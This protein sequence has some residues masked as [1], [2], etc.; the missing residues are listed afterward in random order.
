MVLINMKRLISKEELEM[1]MRKSLSLADVLK[2]LKLCD[3]GKSRS[4]IRTLA[5]E[6]NIDL[7]KL[8]SHAFQIKYPTVTKICPQCSNEFKTQQGHPKETTCCSYKC[9][10]KFK[11]KPCSKEQKKNIRMGILKYLKISDLRARTQ[12]ETIICPHCKSSFEAPES[13]HRIYCSNRCVVSCKDLREKNKKAAIE[14]V[15][16]GTHKGWK[17]RKGRALSYPEQFF[18]TV[19]NNNKIQFEHDLP[20]G[21]WFVDFAMKDKM[22]ALEIDGKQHEY[23][24]RKIKDIEKDTYLQSQGWTVHRIKWKSINNEK[25]SLYIKDE[26]NKFLELYTSLA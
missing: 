10:N 2:I 25:G 7:S 4:L 1:A 5:G 24:E 16:N 11:A 12:I 18:E 17:S 26:I 22:I 14:R 3:N 23:P 20:V 13:R 15:K 21:R 6:L 8:N 9:S 19:L